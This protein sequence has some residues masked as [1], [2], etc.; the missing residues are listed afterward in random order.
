MYRAGLTKK[1]FIAFISLGIVSLFADITYEGGGSILG[2]YVEIL[3][4][5]ALLA[6]F[7][8]VAEFFG[9]V[10]RL[11][12]GMVAGYTAS[13]KVYWLLTFLGYSTNFAIPA[14][15][16]VGRPEHVI[17]L[18]F[19]E[20]AG[21]G[22]RAPARDVIL[23]D[24]TEG[25]GRGKGFGLHELMD[26]IGAVLGPAAVAYSLYSGRGDFRF[27]FSFLAI[28]VVISLFALTV[29]MIMHPTVKGVSKKMSKAELSM[30]FWLFTAGTSFA[31]LGFLQW[32]SI[33]SYYMQ[34]SGIIPSF[35]IPTLYTAAMLVD[36]AIA[37]PAGFA[38]DKYGFRIVTFAPLFAAMVPI[39]L[40]T[41][42]QEGFIIT[43]VMWGVFMGLF[44]TVMR[45]S[46][47]DLVDASRRAYAYGIYSFAIGASW[48][49]GTLF[50]SW[51]IETFPAAV[52]AFSITSEAIATVLIMM[53]FKH[54]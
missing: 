13:S 38:Y 30:K 44:E 12:G 52:M 14:L 29:A 15:A 11:V 42:S 16:L 34:A 21:K 23:A 51:I 26:Q 41:N 53:A 54:K 18:V 20:R 45:A 9:Y 31:M 39:A 5:S 48:M 7:I 4:A 28:P 19:I 1:A 10:M 33:I 24:V 27:A 3:G 36:A 47:A 50:I 25:I 40:L 35:M 6:G 8:G 46:I 32:R 37:L 49:I 22:L 17:A 43:A 2:S